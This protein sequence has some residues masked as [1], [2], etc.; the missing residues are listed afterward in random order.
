MIIPEALMSR[1]FLT[2]WQSGCARSEA[3]T[4]SANLANEP[5]RPFPRSELLK[6]FVRP[7]EQLGQRGR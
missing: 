4:Q 3:R 7:L 6:Y 2:F 5:I 1:E